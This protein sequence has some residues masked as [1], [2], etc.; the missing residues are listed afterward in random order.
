MTKYALVSVSDK[1]NLDILLDY[2]YIKGY[3]ILSTGGTYKYIYDNHEKTRDSL[4]QIS[5]WTGSPEILNGRVKTLHPKIYGGILYDS[6]FDTSGI[7]KIDLVVANLYPFEKCIQK[8]EVTEEEAIENIDI[9][10]V[11]L[12]RA[13][14]KN[15]KNVKLLVSPFDYYDATEKFNDN[16]FWK[17]MA[18]KG[19]DH[20]TWYDSIITN[21]YSNDICYR[22]YSKEHTLKYGCNPYQ[23][24]AGIFSIDYKRLPFEILNGNPGYIN[25]I[26]AIQ[27]WNLVNELSKSTQQVAAASFKHTA[28]AGVA[29]GTKIS[30]NE[31]EFYREKDINNYSAESRAFIKARNADPLSS[32]GDFISISG[33]VDTECAKLIS[34]EV[35]DGIIAK[36][37]T[38]AALELLKE[39]KKGAYIILKTINFSNININENHEYREIGGVCLRQGVNNTSINIDDEI[40]IVTSNKNIS[41]SQK[42][43]M[44]L[45]TIT[46]KYTPSN[47]IAISSNG[48]CIGVGAGQ[49]NRVDC[50]KI[51]GEKANLWRLRHHP[52]TINLYS[53]FKDS[54]KRQEKVNAVYKYLR[55]DFS[56]QQEL[57]NWQSLF[58]NI[59]DRLTDDEKKDFLNNENREL[60]LSSDAFM[61]FRDNIDTGVRY[62][63][64]SFIQPGGSVA[65][66]SVINACNEYNTLMCFTGKRFFLH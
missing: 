5:D 25:T 14:A 33:T 35:S 30:E 23:T 41:E 7:E 9:G 52:K 16:K 38:D 19:F 62:N 48:V 59:P 53:K 22:R 43:D 31:V 61:P 26:D 39:K 34:R 46:L 3:T 50:I 36:N 60:V 18:I 47:S 28:P 57:K 64:N 49:Q 8:E 55:Y 65:D 15:Y 42:L 66:Q 32:F 63:I 27:S 24:G 56:G 44:V 6:R 4:I 2:L 17:S 40:N 10:G 21:Y 54:I 13:A 51:A 58:I 29:L 45:A 12:I 20:A 37:Y 11:S 1:S